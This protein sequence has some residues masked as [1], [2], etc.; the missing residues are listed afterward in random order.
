MQTSPPTPQRTLILAKPLGPRKL[1]FAL[2]A[3]L[4]ALNAIPDHPDAASEDEDEGESALAGGRKKVEQ[5]GTGE[6]KAT[7]KKERRK[8][9]A[10]E[11]KVQVGLGQVR[12]PVNVLIV[13]DNH[14][15]QMLLSSYLKRRGINCALAVNGEE[16]VQKWVEG[17]FHLVLMDIL[18]PVMD[19]IE[20]TRQI[21]QIERTRREQRSRLGTFTGYHAA[22]VVIVALTAST[23]PTDRDEALA[24][25]CNDYLTKPVSLIWLEKKIIEWG[26]MQALIDFAAFEPPPLPWDEHRSTPSSADRG[27]SLHTGS[28][29]F[30]GTLVVMR[31][32][33]EELRKG[34]SDRGELA[35]VKS[36]ETVFVREA[37]EDMEIVV[38]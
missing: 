7:E 19:G 25:G 38:N 16:A 20:A 17:K 12:P 21:R 34:E 18:M 15:N 3:S 9:E 11:K 30:Q 1:L 28:G 23:S 5:G 2:R 37:D 35:R 31:D 4:D 27:M 10:G 8:K 14:V 13:E 32:V 6:R 36:D 26:S 29:R 33:A 22:D 24:A